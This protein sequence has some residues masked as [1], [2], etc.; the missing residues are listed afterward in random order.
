MGSV[1]HDREDDEVHLKEAVAAGDDDAR[2]ALAALLERRRGEAAREEIIALLRPAAEAGHAAALL[3]LA[4]QLE[5]DGLFEEAARAYLG[6]AAAGHEDAML[7]VSR[8]YREGRGVELDSQAANA[9]QRRALA[10]GLARISATGTSRPDLIARGVR[11]G[12]P[13]SPRNGIDSGCGDAA[14]RGKGNS[15]L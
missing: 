13:R 3:A 7:A 14:A 5:G 15:E 1:F 6:A 10:A 12:L 8:L 4:R 2:V 9:W 11:N